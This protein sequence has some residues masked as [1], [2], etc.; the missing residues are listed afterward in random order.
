[1]IKYLFNG[2][3]QIFTHKNFH[4]GIDTNMKKKYGDPSLYNNI[5]AIGHFCICW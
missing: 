5:L 4:I 2:K 1:M 3:I